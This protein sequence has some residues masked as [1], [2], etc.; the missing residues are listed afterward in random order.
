MDDEEGGPNKSDD[1]NEKMNCLAPE[2]PQDWRNPE[3]LTK[4]LKLIEQ[5]LWLARSVARSVQ[6]RV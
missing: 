4:A 6:V 2:T 3:N 1:I 5:G